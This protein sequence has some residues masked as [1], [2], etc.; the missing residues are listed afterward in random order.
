MSLKTPSATD[1]TGVAPLDSVHRIN[2]MNLD[3]RGD[4]VIGL[5]EEY[6]KRF[7]TDTPKY[8]TYPVEPELLDIFATKTRV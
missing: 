2:V 4:S 7:R 3:T 8:T 5:A 1:M 6:F